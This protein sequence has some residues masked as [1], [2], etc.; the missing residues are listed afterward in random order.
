M[1]PRRRPIRSTRRR[2]AALLVALV[3]VSIAVA[4]MY[5]IVQLALQTHREVNLEQRRTQTRWILESAV[6]RAAAQLATDAEYSGEQWTVSAEELGKRYGAEVRILVERV[7][8][9]ADWRQ[10]QVVAD[11]PVDLPYRV[12]Q[13]RVFRM[14]VRP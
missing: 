7:E 3:C 10:V 9:Q 4:V 2:G 14:Q 12:R 1:Q 5:G 13:T 11:H 6:D 8:G